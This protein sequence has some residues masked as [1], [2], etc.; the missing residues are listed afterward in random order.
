MEKGDGV[1]GGDEVKSRGRSWRGDEV[2]QSVEEHRSRRRGRW[3]V[4]RVGLV[5]SKKARR[6]RR[7]AALR[8][9]SRERRRSSTAR[10]LE[11]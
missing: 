8:M 5:G 2:R 1:R 10:G 7:E 11:S 9:V 3:S 4:G 6:R